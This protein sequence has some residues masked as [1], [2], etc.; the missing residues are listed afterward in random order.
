MTTCADKRNSIGVFGFTPG[1]PKSAAVPVSGGAVQVTVDWRCMPWP[2][3]FAWVNENSPVPVLRL[4][5]APEKLTGIPWS[6]DETLPVP[7]ATEWSVF[8]VV[9]VTVMVPTPPLQVSVICSLPALLTPAARSATAAT[10]GSARR[11][12]ISPPFPRTDTTVVLAACAR[13][14]QG[15]AAD[16]RTDYRSDRA[17]FS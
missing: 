4:M 13:F 17:R 15:P 1:M 2:L 8:V 16:L 5:N 3:P 7:Q 14:G 6:D 10:S 11:R 9:T 12:R